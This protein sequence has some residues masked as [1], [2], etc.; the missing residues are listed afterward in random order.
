MAHTVL[1]SSLSLYHYRMI[2]D[3][4][5]TIVAFDGLDDAAEQAVQLANA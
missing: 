4:G 1:E 2:K 5:L 3:S